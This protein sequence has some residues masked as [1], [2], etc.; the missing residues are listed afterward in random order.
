[1]IVAEPL[2]QHGSAAVKPMYMRNDAGRIVGKT[3]RYARAATPADV[4]RHSTPRTKASQTQVV[5]PLAEGAIMSSS[6]AEEFESMGR[7]GRTVRAMGSLLLAQVAPPNN[8]EAGSRLSVFLLTP[9]ALG[10]RLALLAETFE[11]HKAHKCDVVY[12]PSVP[13]TTAGALAMYARAD[14]T[15]PMVDVGQDELR[16]AATHDDFESGPVWQGQVLRI[17]P[18]NATSRYF[19]Q[20]EGAPQLAIQSVVQVLSASPLPYGNYG[21][22]YLHYDFEFFSE[23]LDYSEGTQY[24]FDVGI[25]INAVDLATLADTPIASTLSGASPAAGNWKFRLIGGDAYPPNAQYLLYG[26][27]VGISTGVGDAAKLLFNAYDDPS[28]HT[29]AIGQAFFIGMY[30]VENDSPDSPNGVQAAMFVAPPDAGT[31]GGAG[32]VWAYNGGVSSYTGTIIMRVRAMP[33]SD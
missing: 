12:V 6:S 9:S 13:A 19:D 24:E 27:V 1:L 22:L 11:Q 8:V 18:E 16:H 30:S 15:T 21:T 28:V 2:K 20:A 5:A 32:V 23:E 25:D 10:G 7:Q 17:K 29:L 3:M 31:P 14:V 33:L 4:A 26:V